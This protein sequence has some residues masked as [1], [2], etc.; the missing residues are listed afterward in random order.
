MRRGYSYIISDGKRKD[1]RLR[2]SYGDFVVDTIIMICILALIV[3][4]ILALIAIHPMIPVYL[5]G[6]GGTIA[7]IAYSR[8]KIWDYKWRKENEV[9]KN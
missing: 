4:F 6:G 7:L 8:W 9:P 3:L 5:I 2:R 1:F